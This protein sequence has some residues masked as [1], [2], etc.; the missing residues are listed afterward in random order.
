MMEN[1]IRLCKTTDVP[2]KKGIKICLKDDSEIAVFRIREDYYAFENL[3]PHN[4]TP[5]IS[6][7]FIINDFVICPVHLYAFNIKTGKSKDN[8][9]GKLKIYETK[10]E[11][12]YIFAKITK[13]KLFNF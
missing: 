12:G 11:D 2:D 10:I 1:Y 8:I 7:G 3:C 4:H 5:K 9:G 6:D 13:R